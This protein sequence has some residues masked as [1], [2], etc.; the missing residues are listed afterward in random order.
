MALR[1]FDWRDGG[2]LLILFGMEWGSYYRST[3]TFGLP[4]NKVVVVS[5]TSLSL[6]SLFP[7]FR[8]QGFYQERWIILCT[9]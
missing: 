7:A 9:T 6:A 2:V 4:G 1:R 8:R 3:I 5:M